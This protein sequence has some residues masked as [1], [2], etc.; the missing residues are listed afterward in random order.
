MS[1]NLLAALAQPLM[2][3]MGFVLFLLGQR[4]GEPRVGAETPQHL[5]QG[6]AGAYG[7]EGKTGARTLFGGPSLNGTDR[8]RGTHSS[9]VP[10]HPN[11]QSPHGYALLHA[12]SS[13]SPPNVQQVAVIEIFL[14]N[15]LAHYSSILVKESLHHRAVLRPSIPFTT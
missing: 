9:S 10:I 15:A 14:L 8:E 1:W 6:S 12:T 4:A 11:S 5:L 2:V 13:T 3:N 7:E